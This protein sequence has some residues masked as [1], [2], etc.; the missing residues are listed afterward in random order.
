MRGICLTNMSCKIYQLNVQYTNFKCWWSW[1]GFFTNSPQLSLP[2]MFSI[3][4][5]ISDYRYHTLITYFDDHLRGD[6]SNDQLRAP[7]TTLSTNANDYL[8][9]KQLQLHTPTTT[10][11]QPTL[12]TNSELQQPPPTTTPTTTFAQK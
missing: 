1:L 9:I 5:L 12:T 11:V 8:R 6:N 10:F 3:T 4:P 2:P 7:T